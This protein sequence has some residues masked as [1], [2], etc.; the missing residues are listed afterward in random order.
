MPD[1]TLDPRYELEERLRDLH[2]GLLAPERFLPSLLDY[3]VFMPV[4]DEGPEIAGLQTS[5]RA[6]PLSLEAEDGTRVMIL[7]SAP[8]R[9]TEFLRQFPD[10]K[11]GILESLRWILQRSGTGYGISLNP[12]WDLG[13]D[14]D[15]ETVAQLASLAA[16]ASA[17][18]PPSGNA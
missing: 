9:A 6:V 13:L 14:L 17:G 1:Q 12:G 5:T 7:F 16:A 10:Y 15:P 2:Q 8:E 3:Q 18:D 11:G 4:K